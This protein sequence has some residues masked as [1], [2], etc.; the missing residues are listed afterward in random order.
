M[1]NR[2]LCHYQPG[3]WQRC[4]RDASCVA[5]AQWTRACIHLTIL[6]PVRPVVPQSLFPVPPPSGGMNFA[7][8]YPLPEPPQPP[9]PPHPPALLPPPP[10]LAHLPPPPLP[11][12]PHPP[13]QA[14][15]D[16]LPLHLPPPRHQRRRHHDALLRPDPGHALGREHVLGHERLGRRPRRE[17]PR[18]ADGGE[19]P[20]EL[21]RHDRRVR[22][23]DVP[24]D[25]IRQGGARRRGELPGQDGA[26]VPQA[27]AVQ[28]GREGERAEVV[29]CLGIGSWSACWVRRGHSTGLGIF[30]L[31][32]QVRAIIPLKA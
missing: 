18:E 20:R 29:R 15:L 27:G 10:L 8:P 14:V 6:R 24:R 9:H 26:R 1:V 30:C 12:A 22:K 31:L 4:E 7:P 32:P 19:G 13:P 3:L 28:D 16:P 21:A 25:E 17:P 23:E 11:N 2:H 5:A